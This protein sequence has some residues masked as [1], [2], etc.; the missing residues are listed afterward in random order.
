ME[1]KSFFYGAISIMLLLLLMASFGLAHL[2]SVTTMNGNIIADNSADSMAGHHG[3]SGNSASQPS[4]SYANIPESC[5]P[6]AG[7]DITSWK[8]H[9]SHHQET[10]ECLKYFE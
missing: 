6:P 2:G 4:G 7:Q 5:R 9:L 10:K 8:E 1:I 3:N